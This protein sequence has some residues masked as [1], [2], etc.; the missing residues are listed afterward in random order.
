MNV[1]V[2]CVK[3]LPAKIAVM[4][5]LSLEKTQTVTLIFR[6]SDIVNHN[7]LRL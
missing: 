3:A 6:A 4:M 2:G 5:G 7:Q 1:S